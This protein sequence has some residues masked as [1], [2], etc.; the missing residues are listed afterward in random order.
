MARA[1][2]LWETAEATDQ[3]ARRKEVARYTYQRA[4]GSR[5][6]D[7]VRYEPKTFRISPAGKAEKEP[8]PYRLPDWIA[9]SAVHVCEGEKDA[10]R[11]VA[12]G[13]SATCSYS[14]AK[15]PDAICQHFAGKQVVIWPDNDEA[16]GLNAHKCGS[17]LQGHAAAVA[18]ATVPAPHKDVADWLADGETLKEL[19]GVA[20]AAIPFDQ[21]CA[22]HKEIVGKVN[23]Q[24]AGKSTEVSGRNSKGLGEAFAHEGLELF[25]DLR[26]SDAVIRK[27]GDEFT[28]DDKMMA[29]MRERLAE[30]YY[31]TR[32]EETPAGWKS[33]HP[34]LAFGKSAF[35]DVVDAYC[36][37]HQRDP[38]RDEYLTQLPGWDGIERL[39]CLLDDLFEA[40]RSHLAIWA[41]RYA[42]L[43]LVQRT[44]EPGCKLDEVPV[45]IGPGGCGKSTFCAE[46][47]PPQYRKTGFGKIT[48]L[49]RP[50]KE[51]IEATLGKIVVELE[52]MA[53]STKADIDALKG[54]VSEQDDNAVRLAYRR[55]PGSLPRRFITMGTADKP[56]VLPNDSNLRRWAPVRL[57]RG[58]DVEAHMADNRDR[59]F[60]EALHLFSGGERA[61]MR[62]HWMDGTEIRQRAA[63][64]DG[65]I[66]GAGRNGRRQA[67]QVGLPGGAQARGAALADRNLRS[68]GAA[69]ADTQATADGGRSGAAVDG[70]RPGAEAA[71]G[72]QRQVLDSAE[73]AVSGR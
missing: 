59:L 15:W 33:T 38:F 34:S 55:N 51:L 37:H 18:V 9:D 52:E 40:G 36:Y 72:R 73:R 11:L 4:D 24:R 43:G 46:I 68:H 71:R 5:A 19:P 50:K 54:W 32:M 14:P 57:N 2:G 67:R 69:A 12:A 49:H 42:F 1:M 30:K 8:L 65:E 7:K 10:D 3:Q 25:F 28:L 22:A 61:N 16:G 63:D 66:P 17:A 31:Y 62:G 29:A 48:S 44:L 53:G 56:S 41:G 21:W 35:Q 60:A 27:E 6:F 70:L 39:D 58:C 26:R 13:K 23:R 45:L 64:R 20:G 47:V